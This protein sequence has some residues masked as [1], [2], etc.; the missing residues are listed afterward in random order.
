MTHFVE[1][2]IYLFIYL[3]IIYLLFIT[4]SYTNYKID[5]KTETESEK[6]KTQHIKPGYNPTH[7]LE[8]KS[9]TCKPDRQK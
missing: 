9:T 7:T 8:N 5:K 4:E 6:N 3:F 2:F 1:L